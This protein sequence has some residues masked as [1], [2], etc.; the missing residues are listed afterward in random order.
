MIKKNSEY[1]NT[2]LVTVQNDILYWTHRAD[3]IKKKQYIAPQYD[4]TV[5]ETI[6]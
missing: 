4:L 1:H 3:L 6:V 2:F 5:S